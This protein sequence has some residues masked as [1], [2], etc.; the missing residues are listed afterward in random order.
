MTGVGKISVCLMTLF[1]LSACDD[2]QTLTESQAKRTLQDYYDAHPVCASMA[3]GF[4]VETA[5]V[6]YLKGTMEALT[7][8]GLI[9]ATGT[10]YTV[11]TAGESALHPG[12]DKF[13]GGT[14]ICFATRDIQKIDGMTIPADAA[15]LKTM[16]VTFDYAL[17]NVAPWA[18]EP[19]IAVNRRRKRTPDRRVKGT[20]FADRPGSPWKGPARV[21][22]CP[23]E[24]CSDTRGKDLWTHLGDPRGGV[25]GGVYQARFLK[26]QL[27][28]PVSI[29]SQ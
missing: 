18:N 12:A 3:I 20:P 25:W 27:S 15:G 21:A 8:A 26:R 10:R 24:R 6:T 5:N 17:K 11:T 7:K 23:H 2:R 1:I 9:V 13:L 29:I 22:E 19:T 28:L 14:D 16:R 4:P